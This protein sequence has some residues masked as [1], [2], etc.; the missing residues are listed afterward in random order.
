LKK[1]ILFLF[2]VPAVLQSCKKIDVYEKT[3]FLKGFKWEKSFVPEFHFENNSNRSNTIFVV[4]R[5]TNNYPY[6]NIWVKL[7]AKSEKDST[8]VKN[9]NIPLSLDNRNKEWTNKGM[10]DIHETRYRVGPFAGAVGNYTF[11]LENIMRDNPLPEILNVGLR[12]EKD[13]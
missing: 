11:Q 8:I 3:V 12:I 13:N 5:H 10:D 7:T 6:N 2:A 9:L 1:L 4:I